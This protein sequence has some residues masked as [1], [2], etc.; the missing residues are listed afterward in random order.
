MGHARFWDQMDLKYIVDCIIVLHNMS[1][2]FKRH[3]EQLEAE[4][5][6]VTLLEGSIVRCVIHF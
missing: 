1:I 4:E 6:M 5:T 2:D 3:L